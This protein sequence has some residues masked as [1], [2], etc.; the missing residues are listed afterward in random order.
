MAKDNNFISQ[1]PIAATP[2]RNPTMSFLSATTL[3]YTI[4]ARITAATSTRLT[5]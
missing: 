5:L 1:R 3:I 4:R 2:T